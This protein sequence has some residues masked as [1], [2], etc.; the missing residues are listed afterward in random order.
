MPISESLPAVRPRFVAVFVKRGTFAWPLPKETV[1]MRSRISILFFLLVAPASAFAALPNL[2]VRADALPLFVPEGFSV[3]TELSA[4]FNKDGREDVAV[5][6]KGEDER[7]LLVALSEGKGLH[8]IGL[9]EL[10]PYSLGEAQLSAPKGVLV[11]EDLTGG[12]TAVS[13]LYRY[14]YEAASDR[15]QLIG[16]DVDLYSRTNQHDATKISTNRLTGD[17]VTIISKLTDAGDYRDLKP[18]RSKVKIE[19]LYIENAPDP[20]DTVG[21]GDN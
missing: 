18:K 13:S 16:D 9:G 1:A 2:P 19:K 11:V 15:M 5:V 7:Y 17:R 14:R 3:E 6:V 10:E 4:D 21:F 20:S 12:T 8:R